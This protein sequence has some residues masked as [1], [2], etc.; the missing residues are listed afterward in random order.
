M[1]RLMCDQFICKKK[2][3]RNKHHSV[4]NSCRWHHTHP[5]S[6]K[7]GNGWWKIPGPG[8]ENGKLLPTTDTSHTHT[9]SH[10]CAHKDTNLLVRAHIYSRGTRRM[11][12][13]LKTHMR[14]S[15]LWHD[16]SV[17]KGLEV[18]SYVQKD[19]RWCLHVFTWKYTGQR[20]SLKTTCQ[21]LESSP[22][23]T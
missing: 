2:S 12:E 17:T 15:P 22:C 4:W 14:C 16:V 1:C 20:S 3:T 10:T 7:Q 18:C 9:H 11:T 19:K 6:W 21:I 23:S 8:C 5:W 13:C